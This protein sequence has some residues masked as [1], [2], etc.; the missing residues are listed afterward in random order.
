M[1]ISEKHRFI[2]IHIYKNAG[3]SITEA[4][5]PLI[6]KEWRWKINLIL[7]KLK[8]SALDL[9]PFPTHVNTQEVIDQLGKDIFDSYFSF[10][11]VR[12]PWDWQVSLFKYMQKEE[13]H[14]QH[15]LANK[16]QCFD[17]YIEWRCA[18]DVRFQKD[19]I[20]SSE[21]ELLVDFV[22][23][24]ENLEQDFTEICQRIGI[25][26]IQLPR[27]N[28]SNTKPYRDFYNDKTREMVRA[29]FEP[30][31]SLFNYSF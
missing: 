20:Y 1:L 8:V 14:H 12:N 9:Q 24:F 27:I 22:G 10:A 15:E 6:A 16:F 18:E 13:G 19:F 29:T 23:R 25:P 4:L 11:I 17:Q 3:S 28:V 2:F 7:H 26:S 5:K 30:D 31:I 21:G